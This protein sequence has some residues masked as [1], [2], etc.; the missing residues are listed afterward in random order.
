MLH[1]RFTW[2]NASIIAGVTGKS[3]YFKICSGAVRRPL[4][5]EFIKH[6]RRHLR[7]KLLIVWDGA[8]IHRSKLVMSFV[9]SLHGAVVLCRLPA[10]APELNP[11]EGIFGYLKE[12]RLGNLCP[13]SVHEVRATAAKH[14]SA[15][16]RRASLVDS[17]W[18]LAKLRL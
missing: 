18:H 7:K 9:A 4:V 1:H 3:F 16:R 17:F 13:D 12:R 15:M 14:L 11:A 5:I 2:K 6:L 10:Y 8:P